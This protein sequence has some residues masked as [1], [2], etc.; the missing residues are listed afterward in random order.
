M[1][2]CSLLV[3]ALRIRGS[4]KSLSAVHIQVESELRSGDSEKDG[5]KHRVWD[6]MPRASLDRYERAGDSTSEPIDDQPPF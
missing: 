5:V 1:A 2:S 6:A 4:M 3:E